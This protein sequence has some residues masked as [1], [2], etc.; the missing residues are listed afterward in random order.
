MIK[1]LSRSQFNSA[2]DIS[3]GTPRL[4]FNSDVAVDGA[5]ALLVNIVTQV[6]PPTRGV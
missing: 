4:K 5:K 6:S 1:I 3:T 2:A